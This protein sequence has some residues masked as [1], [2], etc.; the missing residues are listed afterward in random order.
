MLRENVCRICA[1]VRDIVVL[2]A[3]YVII[4]IISLAFLKTSTYVRN[5]LLAS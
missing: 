2:V 1:E 3:T 4:F 5:A